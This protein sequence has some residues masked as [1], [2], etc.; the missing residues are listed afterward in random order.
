MSEKSA[1]E[2]TTA[3]V[4]STKENVC[5]NSNDKNEWLKMTIQF[6]F[7]TIYMS[8]AYSFF[9]FLLGDTVDE[10]LREI[11]ELPWSVHRACLTIGAMVEKSFVV[12]IPL[13]CCISSWIAAVCTTTQHFLLERKRKEV[14]AC[15]KNP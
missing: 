11:R 2:M 14:P 9:K 10:S 12:F 13:F 6:L 3:N 7:V 5:T 4:S 1:N 8:V 15:Q